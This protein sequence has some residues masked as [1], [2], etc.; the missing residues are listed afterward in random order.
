MKWISKN[1]IRGLIVVVPIAITILVVLQIFNL[2]EKLLGRHLPIHFPGLPLIAVFL[3][4]VLVGWLSSYWV[5]KRLLELGDRLL[6]A[7]PFVKF[8]YNS[9]KQL[10]TAM[11]ESQ[12]LFKQAVLVPYPHPGVKALGFIMPELSEPLVEKVGADNVCVFVP[13]SLNLTSG[14]NIIVPKRDIILLDITSESALQY[15]LTAG[16]VMPRRPDN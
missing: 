4:I 15:I 8:I 14:F 13:M 7:I 12:Q 2:A 1:F 10:S 9:V 5:L 3:L 6:G 16:A 11:L